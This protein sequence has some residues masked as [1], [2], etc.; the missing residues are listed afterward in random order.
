MS[1][2]ADHAPSYARHDPGRAPPPRSRPSDRRGGGLDD[3]P[4]RDR[5]GSRGGDA[6]EVTYGVVVTLRD[7]YGFVRCYNR[8]GP[9]LFFHASEVLDGDIRDLRAG[10]ECKFF[11]RDPAPGSNPRDKDGKSTATRLAPLTA[12]DRAPK[13]VAEGVEGTVVRALRGR[14]K[15]DSYGGRV[16][17][18]AKAEDDDEKRATDKKRAADADDTPSKLA[19]VGND[20]PSKL[21]AA[22]NDTPSKLAAAGAREPSASLEFAGSDLDESCPRLREGDRVAFDIVEHRFTGERRAAGI[23]FVSRAPAAK[24][25]AARA[26]PAVAD[27]EGDEA[28]LGRVEKITGRYGFIRKIGGR[29]EALRERDKAEKKSEA[30]GLESA[31]VPPPSPSSSRVVSRSR[32]PHVFFHYSNLDRAT[33]EEDLRAGSAVYFTRGEEGRDGKPTATRVSIAPEE[34][35]RALE[36]EEKEALAAAAKL[37]AP[38]TGA[39]AEG[40]WGK[41]AAAADAPEE[42][43]EERGVVTIIKASYGFIK[44]CERAQDLFFHFTEVIG[45]EA[46]VS[47]GQDV[48]FRVRHPGVGGGRGAGGGDKPVAVRVA[49]AP[50]GSAVFETVEPKWR[51]G[52]CVERLVFGR[53]GGFGARGGDDR[54]GAPGALEYALREGDAASE[55]EA[56]DAREKTETNVKTNVKTKGVLQYNRGGLADQKSNPR[57]GDVVRFR[58][59]ADN[60]TRRRAAVDV[61]MVRFAGVVVAVKQQG[62]YGFLEHEHTEGEEVRGGDEEEEE[63]AEAN[64]EE[65]N[66]GEATAQSDGAPA[67]SPGASAPGATPAD[68]SAPGATSDSKKKGNKNRR[69]APGKTRVFFH[70]SEVERG[71]TLREGDEV[72]YCV[73]LPGRG[74]GG[75]GDGPGGG[76]E[77]A[78][79]RV[80]RTKEAP[81]STRPTFT[82]RRTDEIGEPEG[83][84]P[85]GTQ[86]TQG[87]QFTMAKMPDGTRG[88]AMGRGAGLA[89]A[90]R[91]AISK[92]KLGATSFQPPKPVGGGSTPREKDVETS[93]EATEDA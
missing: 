61:E 78:A 44:C 52:V 39:D 93:P 23:R 53:A 59:K 22:G 28:E 72:E 57:P 85:T 86:F 69:A 27:P 1:P 16:S 30:D 5:R 88:F 58:V 89:E 37:S 45:G 24:P 14:T 55:S 36:R 46:A 74:G 51:R 40:R 54:G 70:G 83:E 11:I 84:R 18:A 47:V 75:R 91:A 33:R 25:S 4:D 82:N 32:I 80:V 31:G 10:D 35:A 65:A 76:R 2:S 17:F 68:A 3:D 19:A 13:V 92:L 56:T 43:R 48:T 81:E 87:S 21:A 7:S 29:L 42:P 38:A 60:R 79:R 50:K 63:A 20:T 90:A 12:E 6:G 8:P 49:P 62:S 64:E 9:Q 77:P 41:S 67:F 66:E 34:R 26:A 71:V 15:M 73:T